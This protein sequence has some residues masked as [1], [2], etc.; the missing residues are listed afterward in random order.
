M[1]HPNP[2]RALSCHSGNRSVEWEHENNVYLAKKEKILGGS[3][4]WCIKFMGCAGSASFFVLM[5]HFNAPLFWCIGK[6]VRNRG[7]QT[8]GMVGKLIWQI[9]RN[10]TCCNYT[11]VFF[12][13]NNLCFFYL[14][15]SNPR[16]CCSEKVAQTLL[17]SLYAH[18]ELFCWKSQHSDMFGRFGCLSRPL[19]SNSAAEK[20]LFWHTPSVGTKKQFFHLAFLFINIF[21]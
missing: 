2:W 17:L 1:W 3:Q 6:M 18:L 8:K 14:R 16:V 21:W 5:H 10:I 15:R 19:I 20:P 13:M 11:I 12:L 7:A 4:K 9:S